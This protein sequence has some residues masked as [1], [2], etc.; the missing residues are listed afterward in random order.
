[1]L[2]VRRGLAAGLILGFTFAT[3]A[4]GTWLSGVVADVVS[5]QVVMQGVAWLGV[6]AALLS[7]MLPGRPE[8]APMVSEPAP[9]ARV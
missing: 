7:L 5:L 2:P 4:L 9:A 3:G 6:P 8:A 1:L